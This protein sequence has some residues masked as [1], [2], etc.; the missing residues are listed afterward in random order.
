M[1]SKGGLAAKPKPSDVAGVVARLLRKVHHAIYAILKYPVHPAYIGL[2]S[3][4]SQA[5]LALLFLD[6]GNVVF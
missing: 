1:A 4:L 2:Q 3:S 6:V 5:N